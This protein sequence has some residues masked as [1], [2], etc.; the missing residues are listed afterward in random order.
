ML[1][2]CL[3]YENWINVDTLNPQGDPDRPAKRIR[4]MDPSAGGSGEQQAEL[5]RL[6]HG[7]P[8]PRNQSNGNR[9]V[10][11]LSRSQVAMVLRAASTSGA[12]STLLSGLDGAADSALSADVDELLELAD[13][14]ERRLSRSLLSGLL[15]LACFPLDGTQ[16]GVAQLARRLHMSP[17]A[18]HRYISTLLAAELLE[19]DPDT[20]RY[21]LASKLIEPDS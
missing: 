19:R 21:R 20:R 5:D 14:D 12:P 4:D 1:L 10:L 18:T 16:L 13:A 6:D 15:V 11:T 2:A 7:T 3:N 8:G 17:S 9:I